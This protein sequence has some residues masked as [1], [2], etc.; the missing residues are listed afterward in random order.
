ML[1]AIPCPAGCLLRTQKKRPPH[2]LR[3]SSLPGEPP[4]LGHFVFNAFSNPSRGVT[5]TVVYTS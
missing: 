5:Y 3:C 1:Q 4:P 2:P